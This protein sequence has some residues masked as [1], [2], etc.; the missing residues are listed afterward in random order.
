MRKI[1][2]GVVLDDDLFLEYHKFQKGEKFD[3]KKIRQLLHYFKK[4]I[5]S[6]IRQYQTNGVNLTVNL[7]AEMAHAGLRMQSLEELAEN[8]TL[9]KIILSATKDTFPYINIMKD[10]QVLENN[11]SASFDMAEPRE[12]AIKHLTSMC[13]HAKNIIIYDRYFSNKER[14]ITLIKKILPQKKLDII[15]N[16]IRQ[17]HVDELKTWCPLW[18][19]IPNPQ[20]TNR[21]D[22]YLIIDNRLEI[23]LTSGFD[24]LNDTSGDFTYII[25]NISRSR[26][27]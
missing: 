17:E 8:H 15:Y 7:K 2:N 13:L 6:N 1:L 20:M 25:R 24:H 22:R 27:K 14:N 21:H 23:I 16:T 19:F 5:V 11:F 26:F 12:L 10:N 3:K 4:E 9:Y 18:N